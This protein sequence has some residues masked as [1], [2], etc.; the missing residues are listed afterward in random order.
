MD[1][2]FGINASNEYVLIVSGRLALTID[3]ELVPQMN[4][5][6]NLVTA[7]DR[8]TLREQTLREQ[9]DEW[10]SGLP[11]SGPIRPI[12]FDEALTVRGFIHLGPIGPL[13]APV[14]PDP[15]T[16]YGHLPLHGLCSG[17]EVFYRYEHYPTS[18]RINQ[19]NGKVVPKTYA[20]P[21]SELPLVPTGLAAVA[22]YALKSLLPARWRYELRP[23]IGIPI[24]YGASVPMHG[25]SGGG[26][27]VMFPKPFDNV[28]PI[29]NPVVLP[30]F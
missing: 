15:D 28:G 24:R 29:A 9:M 17:K 1:I 14:F 19:I 30:I 11:E 3:D 12:P 8:P 6:Q 22:R 16:V 13:T 10:I 2:Q 4:R 26:V 23:G 27:E 7:G 21:M 20:T 18:I 5:Y 25:Q